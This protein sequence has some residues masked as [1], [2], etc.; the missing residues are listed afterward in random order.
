MAWLPGDV[1]AAFVGS[2]MTGRRSALHTLEN[3]ES[4]GGLLHPPVKLVG[5]AFSSALEIGLW[6]CC[7]LTTSQ[8]DVSRRGV[9]LV[10]A[11]LLV[12]AHHLGTWLIGLSGI[13]RSLEPVEQ[14]KTAFDDSIWC[15]IHTFSPCQRVEVTD[16]GRRWDV[17]LRGGCEGDGEAGGRGLI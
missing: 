16:R 6:A 1:R 4:C 17:A 8:E 5:D 14:E 2:H 10:T 7:Q 9:P 3:F 13:L 12:D 11:I 15:C